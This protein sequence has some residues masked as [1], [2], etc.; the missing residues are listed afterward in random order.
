MHICTY[1]VEARDQQ[2]C[3]TIAVAGIENFGL[4]FIK[5]PEELLFLQSSYFAISHLILKLLL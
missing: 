1:A 4:L 2:V 5:Y 3:Y